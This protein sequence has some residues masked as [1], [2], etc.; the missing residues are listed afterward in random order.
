M[1]HAILILAHKDFD[2]VRHLIE[3]FVRDCYVYV[4][5]DKKAAITPEE[6]HSIDS[7]PQ[8]RAV[9]RKYKVHWGGFSILKTEMFL[10]RQVLKDGDCDYVHLISGQD[11]PIKPLDDFLKFFEEHKGK[12]FIRYANIPNRN[13]DHYTFYRFQYFFPYDYID[14]PLKIREAKI[15]LAVKLQKKIGLKR[16]IPDYFDFLYGSTQWF[17]ITQNAVSVLLN[18]TKRNPTFYRRCRWTFAPEEYYIATVL[19]NLLPKNSIEPK[20]LR[21]IRWKYEN[22]NY[23]ANLRKNYFHIL[24]KQK[25]NLFARKLEKGKC[26]DLIKLIDK[27]MLKDPTLEITETGGWRYNGLRKYEYSESVAVALFSLCKNLNVHSVLDFG[28]G[29]GMYV[30]GLRNR[31]IP[32]TGVDANPYTPELSSLILAEGDEPCG[33]A[34]LTQPMETDT[35]FDMILCMDVLTFIPSNY[36]L[37]VYMNLSIL[38]SKYILLSEKVRCLESTVKNMDFHEKSFRKLGFF[39]ESLASN[40]LNK[41]LEKENVRLLLLKKQ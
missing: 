12:E 23:P 18:Y 29:A 28:C 37:V 19:G 30:S 2:Q 13:W 22:E 25:D 31:G 21:F 1:K 33:T 7:M 10:L 9:Y 17:S 16:R 39:K 11:Y 36:L 41:T 38:S 24:T 15:R 34:D 32:A 4:H 27:Y 6:L 14:A 40:I 20:D 3:Y 8:V 35:P 5:I 26:E